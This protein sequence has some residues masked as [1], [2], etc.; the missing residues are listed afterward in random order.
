M[1]SYCTICKTRKITD[2]DGVV[3]ACVQCADSLVSKG[4]RWVAMIHRF[5][6]GKPEPGEVFSVVREVAESTCNPGTFVALESI[7]SSL[8]SARLARAERYS[9]EAEARKA[10]GI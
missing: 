9:S 2:H 8:V 6:Y 1:P 3:G 7:G 5:I 4:K 10:L